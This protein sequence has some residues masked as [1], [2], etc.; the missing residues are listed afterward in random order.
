[1]TEN[2]EESKEVSCL[3]AMLTIIIIGIIFVAT[4]VLGML[5][6]LM[7]SGK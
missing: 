7:D 2:L 4:L 5:W 3:I 6:G 1:M